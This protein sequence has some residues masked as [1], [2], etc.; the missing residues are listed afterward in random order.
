MS[1]YPSHTIILE[2]TYIERER[3]LPPGIRGEVLVRPGQDVTSTDVIAWG[4]KPSDYVIVDVASAMGIDPDDGSALADAI[5]VREGDYVEPGAPL[6]DGRG[7]RIPRT[8]KKA[9]KSVV[10]LIEA[11]RIILQVNP[12][13]V[14]I[15]A[16][17]P[18]RVKEIVDG[19]GAIIEATGS[20]IQ[21]AWGNG[22]FNSAGYTFEPTAAD[23]YDGLA[24]LMGEDIT[25]SKF[26]GKAIVLTRPLNNM[27]LNVVENQELAG[28]IAPSAPVDLQE[29]AMQLKVPVILTEGFGTLPPTAPIFDLLAKKQGSQTVYD[30][31]VPDTRRNV[32]PEIIIASGRGGNVT[33]PATDIPLAVGMQV[34]LRRA[35]YFGR[36]GKISQLPD[37]PLRLENGLRVPCAQVR[38]RG[39][40][41]VT[42]PLANLDSVGEA[43]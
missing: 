14:E 36:I 40:E 39:G 6:V 29:N 32:R 9:G 4:T 43:L 8:P 24:D 5:I 21:A 22:R 13:N 3:V 38:L 15:Q 17:L 10:R 1:F 30:A 27:D 23:G 25:L 28:I 34:R 31:A 16:R 2:K 18:G 33:A 11:G 41:T 42:V 7:R 26:R 20:V 37:K 35:P 19:R 12:E